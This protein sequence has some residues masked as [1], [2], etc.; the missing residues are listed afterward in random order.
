MVFELPED[1][2]PALGL[3]FV[4]EDAARQI[5]RKW[6]EWVGPRDEG[7]EL[8]VSII[9]GDIPGQRPGYSVHVGLDAQALLERYKRIG[10]ATDKDLFVTP[11]ECNRGNNL[12]HLAAFKEAYRRWKTYFLAPVII[13]KDETKPPK[14]L[15]EMKI[16][17]S[18]IHFRHVSEIGEDDADWGPL[19]KPEYQSEVFTRICDIVREGVR[20]PVPGHVPRHADCGKGGGRTDCMN[21]TPPRRPEPNASGEQPPPRRSAA[22]LRPITGELNQP[23]DK[24]GQPHRPRRVANLGRYLWPSSAKKV[25]EENRTALCTVLQE[26]LLSYVTITISTIVKLL[27]YIP[28]TSEAWSH[29]VIDTILPY[30]DNQSIYD[31]NV[32]QLGL[33]SPCQI[34]HV[35]AAYHTQKLVNGTI[36][37]ISSIKSEQ[38]LQTNVAAMHKSIPFLLGAQERIMAGARALGGSKL[39]LEHIALVQ[40]DLDKINAEYKRWCQKVARPSRA[41]KPGQ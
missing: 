12:S 35:M 19:E 38:I 10:L 16:Y 18:K 1:R 41:R 34:S 31:S 13:N 22:P 5:F 15:H 36:Y 14:V 7:E 40:D 20:V 33:L 29:L 37:S 4:N 25:R 8:R 26:E 23:T 28:N 9:E 6:E 30:I 27:E 21:D 39:S 2:P 3:G 32:R 24:P 17:K 11:S